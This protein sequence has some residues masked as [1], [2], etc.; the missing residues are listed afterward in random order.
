MQAVVL[1]NGEEVYRGTFGLADRASQRPARPDD[2]YRIASQAKALITYFSAGAG[3]VGTI[4]DYAR[5]CQML[6]KGGELDGVRPLSPKTVAMMLRHQLGEL[7][8]WDRHDKFGLGFQLITAAGQYGDQATPGSYTWGGRYCSEYTIDPAEQ[9]VMLVYTN[10]HPT[11]YYSEVVRKF[12]VLVY[13][14]LE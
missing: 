9:L 14:A 8:V 11:P 1:Q 10:V 6:L 13:Q 4:A 2:I 12:R 7:E 3:S 5:F